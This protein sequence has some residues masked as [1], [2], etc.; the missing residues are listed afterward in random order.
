MSQQTPRGNRPIRTRYLGHVIG[1]EPIRDQYFLIRSVPTS[2]EDRGSSKEEKVRERVYIAREN[3]REN[4]RERKESACVCV[5][6]LMRVPRARLLSTLQFGVTA[7]YCESLKPGPEPESCR[8]Y[9]CYGWTWIKLFLTS[10]CLT[11]VPTLTS[12]TLTLKN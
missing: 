5:L 7:P 3:E 1:Y 9:P 4:K 10:E 12:K 2:Q 6:T 11:H 8:I